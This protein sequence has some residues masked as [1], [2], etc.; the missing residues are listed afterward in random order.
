MW[1]LSHYDCALAEQLF[2]TLWYGEKKNTI[3]VH[4]KE[5]TE[6]RKKEKKKK[7]TVSFVLNI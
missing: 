3:H 5:E 6:K 7:E 2:L 4:K 1:G